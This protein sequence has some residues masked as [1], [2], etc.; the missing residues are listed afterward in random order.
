MEIESYSLYHIGIKLKN[1]VNLSELKA[2]VQNIADKLKYELIKK[3]HKSLGIL[4][5]DVNIGTEEIAKHEEV[6]ILLNIP[7]RALNFVGKNPEK[8]TEIFTKIIKEFKESGDFEIDSVSNFYEILI[9]ASMVNSKSPVE[10]L[11]DV[12]KIERENIS[13]ID[14]AKI[15]GIHI[16]GGDTFEVILEP[17]PHKPHKSFF[18]KAIKQTKDID[19]AIAYH[20]DIANYLKNLLT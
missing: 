2:L 15:A 7:L 18:V 12:V 8:V 16:R 19:E 4:P 20:K 13:K 6:T 5:I 1:E 11:N 3:E 9:E 17:H 14:D 10:I